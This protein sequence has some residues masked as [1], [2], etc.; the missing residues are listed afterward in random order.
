MNEEAFEGTL[1]LEMLAELGLV[2][3]ETIEI[4]VRKM[5]ESDCQH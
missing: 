5:Q 2:D 1:I 4:T 3:E